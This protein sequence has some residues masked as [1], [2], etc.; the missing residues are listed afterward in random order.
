LGSEDELGGVTSSGAAALWK[1]IYEQNFRDGD[2]GFF[3]N[4]TFD[5]Q[6]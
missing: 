5:Q 4:H 3:H 6:F 1:L 2:L